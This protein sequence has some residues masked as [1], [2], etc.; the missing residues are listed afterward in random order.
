MCPL[1]HCRQT[2]K[3]SAFDV[4]LTQETHL[5]LQRV[6]SC[7]STFQLRLEALRLLRNRIMY[8]DH[9]T[10]VAPLSKTYRRIVCDARQGLNKRSFFDSVL[11][12]FRYV[13]QS[14]LA[15][16]ALSPDNLRQLQWS[17]TTCS[18]KTLFAPPSLGSA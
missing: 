1:L 4:K 9:N 12:A 17:A 14:I 7:N 5:P 6:C 3:T 8:L 2:S 10:P 16:G 18:P 11:F 15:E 13:L